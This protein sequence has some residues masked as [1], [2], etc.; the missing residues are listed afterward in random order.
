[1]FSA[2]SRFSRATRNKRRPILELNN[3][4]A[5]L[6]DPLS[7]AASALDPITLPRFCN[8]ELRQQFRIMLH[9]FLRRQASH[10]LKATALQRSDDAARTRVG[11]FVSGDVADSCWHEYIKTTYLAQIIKE[12]TSQNY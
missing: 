12:Q 2:S 4:N 3:D 5:L 8:N 10:N 9:A 7:L 1:L 11:Y 6:C